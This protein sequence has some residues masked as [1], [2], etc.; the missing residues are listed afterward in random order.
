MRRMVVFIGYLAYSRKVLRSNIWFVEDSSRNR[1][2]RN[3]GVLLVE[4]AEDS[5]KWKHER[6][7]EIADHIDETIATVSGSSV[8]A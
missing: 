6:M 8:V 7:T 5:R 4:E 1:A 3:R 2:S